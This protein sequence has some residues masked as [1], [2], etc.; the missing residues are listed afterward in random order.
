MKRHKKWQSKRKMKQGEMA[1]I[2]ACWL[3]KVCC[4][5]NDIYVCT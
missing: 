5:Y 4:M 1:D 3:E 2:Q